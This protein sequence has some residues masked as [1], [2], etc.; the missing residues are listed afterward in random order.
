MT[1]EL[2][3]G[4]S[5]VARDLKALGHRITSTVRTPEDNERVGGSPGSLHLTGRAFDVVP[6]LEGGTWLEL[7]A[8]V[9]WTAKKY[10]VPIRVLC[11]SDHLHVDL[12]AV[13]GLSVEVPPRDRG[14]PYARI[15]SQ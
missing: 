15:Y 6:A 10:E 4:L 13:P 3:T 14:K 8:D 9:V 7:I 12:H 2:D 1:V 5:R 11:E